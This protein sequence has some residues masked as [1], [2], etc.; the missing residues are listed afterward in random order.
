VRSRTLRTTSVP[1]SLV[2]DRVATLAGG[3]PEVALA[4]L[5]GVEGVDLR[6]TVRD[7]ASAEADRRLDASATA[8]RGVMHDAIYGEGHADLAAVVLDLCRERGESIGVGESCTGGLLG[9]RLTAVPGSSAV[10]RGGVISYANAVKVARLGVHEHDL[11]EHGA[12]SEP[13]A[14]QMA[15]GA[16]EATGA[17]IGVAI[18]GIA[19]PEGGTAEKPVGT[20]WIATDVRGVVESRRFLLWGDREEIRQRAAQAALDLVRRRLLGLPGAPLGTPGESAAGGAQGTPV[21]HPAR[22]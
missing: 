17:T 22:G 12:V 14:R 11:A 18:T 7:V 1:E 21:A 2:A 13:V 9:A 4:Y 15:A 8:L 10:V 20:V 5:P 3:L 16:R 19:G 6:L